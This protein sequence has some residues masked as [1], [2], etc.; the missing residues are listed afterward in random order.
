MRVA[1]DEAA[2]DEVGVHVE[3][4]KPGVKGKDLSMERL[5]DL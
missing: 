2:K 5:A 1:D 4:R 3:K